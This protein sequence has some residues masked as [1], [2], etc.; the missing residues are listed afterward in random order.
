MSFCSAWTSRIFCHVLF[1]LRLVCW[2]WFLRT[3][4]I[5]T[6]PDMRG[7]VFNYLIFNL[8]LS[9]V[10]IPDC[11]M[12]SK[13]PPSHGIFLPRLQKSLMR[14]VDEVT[15]E[16][17]GFVMEALHKEDIVSFFYKNFFESLFPRL[18]SISSYLKDIAANMSI[19]A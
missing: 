7:S 13:S 14:E 11:K 9:S 15:E 1:H 18:S 3:T 2:A 5:H 19:S 6:P 4:T 8:L 16:Y 10:L 12:S 17:V